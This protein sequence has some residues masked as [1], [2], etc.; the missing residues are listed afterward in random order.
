MARKGSLSRK[1]LYRLTNHTTIHKAWGMDALT[2]H[3][4]TENAVPKSSF[5]RNHHNHQWWWT[6]KTCISAPPPHLNHTY[7]MTFSSDH[8]FPSSCNSCELFSSLCYGAWP[9]A[10]KDMISFRPLSLGLGRV[11]CVY[12]GRRPPPRAFIN[13]LARLYPLRPTFVLKPLSV[14][15]SHGDP[16][17]T[18]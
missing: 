10:T 7:F 3:K 5:W 18:N 17:V 6:K 12:W 9:V 15:W 11:V 8:W 16:G 14:I 1:Q 2:H 4:Y 13:V